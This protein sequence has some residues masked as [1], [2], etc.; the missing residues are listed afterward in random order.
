MTH[1]PVPTRPAT[2]E[3]RRLMKHLIGCTFAVGSFDK[4]FVRDVSA[5]IEATGEITDKQGVLIYTLHYRYRRQHRKPTPNYDPDTDPKAH[6]SKAKR[7]QIE[8][9]SKLIHYGEKE[10]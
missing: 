6:I 4:R 3:E 7:Q 10:P 9:Q 2:D 1:P 5:R 8:Q